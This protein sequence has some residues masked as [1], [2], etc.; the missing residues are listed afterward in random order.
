VL[1][2]P[3]SA[4]VKER[5]ELYLYSP[6]GPSWPLLGWNLL[7]FTLL[8]STYFW[9]AGHVALKT[10]LQIYGTFDQKTSRNCTLLYMTGWFLYC[11]VCNLYPLRAM[12]VTMV[13]LVQRWPKKANHCVL[14]NVSQPSACPP[15]LFHLELSDPLLGADYSDV[16]LGFFLY[17]CFHGRTCGQR[18]HVGIFWTT[19]G[20]LYV[21]RVHPSSFRLL[22]SNVRYKKL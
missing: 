20:V 16:S 13:V 19:L 15:L 7:Y 8:Y 12:L 17:L 9:W 6:S 14:W 18:K 22:V 1:T 21:S 5:I 11:V 3:Y 10:K 4:E 2:T